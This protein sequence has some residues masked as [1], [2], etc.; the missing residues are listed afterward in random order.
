MKFFHVMRTEGYVSH[1]NPEN[2]EY[3]EPWGDD[4]TA[5]YLRSGKQININETIDSF[6]RRLAEFDPHMVSS[7]LDAIDDE[8]EKVGT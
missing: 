7:T 1:L 5:I 8:L 3:Y 6:R 4:S 2:I